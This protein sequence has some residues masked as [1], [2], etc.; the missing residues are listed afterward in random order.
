MKAGDIVFA[1]YRNS[2]VE[3]ISVNKNEVTIMVETLGDLYYSV[4]VPKKALVKI[5]VLQ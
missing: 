2:L 4:I 5:G 3:V 1:A